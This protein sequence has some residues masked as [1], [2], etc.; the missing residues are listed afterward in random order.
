M[1]TMVSGCVIYVKCSTF[2]VV[3]FFS[4]A[5]GSCLSMMQ[6]VIVVIIR[7]AMPI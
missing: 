7:M 2:N 3:L 6:S 5:E 4:A 1:Y